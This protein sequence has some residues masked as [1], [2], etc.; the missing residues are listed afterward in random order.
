MPW[1]RRYA[2]YATTNRAV[3]RSLNCAKLFFPALIPASVTDGVF[4]DRV[5]DR[6]LFIRGP[7]NSE[8]M[9]ISTG[10]DSGLATTAS[11]YTTRSL[12]TI[13]NLQSPN[14]D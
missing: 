3:T 10:L 12:L 13:T 7:H 9:Q 6:V 2:T 4:I 14:S 1:T 5:L 11:F 8:T